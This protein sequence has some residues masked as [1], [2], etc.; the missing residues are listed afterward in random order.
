MGRFDAE[1][2]ASTFG[3][4]VFFGAGVAAALVFPGEET[5]ALALFAGRL[6]H[7]SGAFILLRAVTAAP[8]STG[9]GALDTLRAGAVFAGESVA[10][11]AFLQIDTVVVKLL[12]GEAAAGA[13]QAGVRFVVVALVAAQALAGFFVPSLV[14]RLGDRT[15]FA[16]EARRVFV[17]FAGLGCTFLLA[18][19]MWGDGIALA[20]YG[21]GYAQ[22]AALAPLLGLLVCVRCLAAGAG[23]VLLAAGAQTWRLLATLVA[24]GAYLAAAAIIG[25]RFGLEGLLAVNVGALAVLLG[26]YLFGAIRRLRVA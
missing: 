24:M 22:T 11:G 6:A 26:I 3:N 12:L 18:F 14:A 7:A 25:A 21:P 20:V 9:V 1:A 17:V 5:V 2:R 8:G 4:G 15:G 23:I 10:T 19:A 13:Y 16:R